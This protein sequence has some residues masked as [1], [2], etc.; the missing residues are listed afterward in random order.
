MASEQSALELDRVDL[1]GLAAALGQRLRAAGLPTTPERAARFAEALAL[2]TPR[3]R[4]ELYWT[5]RTV[6]VSSQAQLPTFD[7]V[8]AAVFDP[9]LEPDEERGDPYSPT[10][11]SS[12]SSERPPDPPARQ[13]ESEREPE[14]PGRIRSASGALAADAQHGPD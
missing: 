12:R 3:L 14:P 11:R 2:A 6:F 10:L 7:R 5:A 9:A 4:S 13:V 8:F 1:P